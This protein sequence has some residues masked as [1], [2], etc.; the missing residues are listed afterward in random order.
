MQ[1]NPIFVGCGLLRRRNKTRMKKTLRTFFFGLVAF[2]GLSAMAQSSLVSTRF[3]ERFDL[4]SGPDS[5]TSFHTTPST[6]VPYWNDTTAFFVSPGRSYHAKV[7][8]F[9][10]IIFETNTFSTVGNVFVRLTFDQICKVHFGQQGYIMVSNNNGATWTRLNN[11]HYQGPSTNFSAASPYFN[12]ISYVNPSNFPYWGGITLTGTGTQPTQSWWVQETFNVSNLLGGGPSGTGNGFAQCKVRFI[13]EYR[14]P[15]GAANPAGWFVDNVKVDAAPCELQA[16]SYTFNFN[17]RKE[18]IGAR[19]FISEEVRLRVRDPKTQGLTSGVDSVVLFYNKNNSGWQNLNMT[20]SLTTACPDSAYYN[21]IFTGLVVGDTIDWYLELYDCTSCMNKTRVPS[22]TSTPN[23]NTFWRAPSPPLVCGTAAPNSFPFVVTTFP[24]T[25]TFDNLSWLAGSGTGATGTTHRGIFP[26]SNPPTGKNWTVT[27]GAT[28][29]GFAWSVRTGSTGTFGTG[30]TGDN[31]TGN[32][33]YLYTEASQGTAG[34][35]TTLI[36]PCIQLKNLNHAVLEFYYHKF[37]ANMGDLILDIDTNSSLTN[38]SP[39]WKLA[40]YSLPG[41][42]QGTTSAAWKKALVNLDPYLGKNIRI[43]FRAT[44]TGAATVDLG[45]MAIDD[46][47]VYEPA[48]AEM[49]LLTWT[50]PQNGFC[51][52][53]AIEPIRVFMR[54]N[55]SVPTVRIPVGYKLWINNNPPIIVRDTL[56]KT[57][58]LGDTT[59]YTFVPK[60]NMSAF[61]NYTLKVFVAAVGDSKR[62]NDTIGPRLIEHKAPLQLFPHVLTFDDGTWASGNGTALNPGTY[63]TTEWEALPAPITGEYTWMVENGLTT[64]TNTGPRFD[65]SCEGNYLYTEASFGGNSPYAFWQ[66]TRCISLTGMTNPVLTFYYHMYGADINAFTVQVVKVG[67]NVWTNIPSA[68]IAVTPAQHT[69]QTNDWKFF[70]VN[71]STYA[72]QIVKLRLVVRKTNAGDKADVAIDNM[73]IHDRAANDVGIE[74]VTRP[75]NSTAIAT[76]TISPIVTIRNFGTTAKTTVPLAFR[77]KDICAPASA[78]TYTATYTGNIAPGASVSYTLTTLPVYYQGDFEIKAWTTLAGDGYAFNDTAQRIST[79]TTE[80][81]IPFG[82]INFEGCAGDQM[83]F[84]GQATGISNGTSMQMWEFG[85][86]NKG[87]NFN[88]AAS[89]NN[90]WVTGL[91]DNYHPGRH[92]VLRVPTLNNFDTIVGAELRFKHKWDFGTDDGGCVEYFNNNQWNLLGNTSVNVGVNWYGSS[93]GSP[94]IL[95][96]PGPGWAGNSGG[97]WVSSSIPLNVWNF[98]TNPLRLR[99]RM[100][101]NSGGR[102]WAMDDFELY[103]PPQNSAAPVLVDTR[104]YIIIPG[105]TSHVKVKIQNSGAKRLDSCLVRYQVNGGAWTNYETIVFS[106][107]LPR[108]STRWYEFDQV[109]V[110]GGAGNYN[111]CVQ[112]ARPNNKQ[113]NL[114]SDDQLCR[115]FTT[116]DEVIITTSNGYCNDF[117]NPATPAWLPL[118]YKNKDLTHDWEMGTPAQSVISQAYSGSKAWMTKLSSNYSSMTQSALHTPFFTLDTNKVYRMHFRHNMFSE[119]YHDGGSVDWSYDGGIT[120]FTLGNVFISGLWYNTVHVTSLDLVR[121]GWSGTS[122]GWDSSVIHFTVQNPGK[123]VFRFR[124]GSD[125]TIMKEGWAVDDFC[126]K[127]APAGIP[128]DIIGIGQEEIEIPGLFLGDVVP[129]PTNDEALFQFNA[130]SREPVTLRIANIHGQ[131]MSLDKIRTENGVNLYKI[132]TASWAPGM[133][134]LSVQYGDMTVTKRFLVQH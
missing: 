116:L 90:A 125:Y 134:L 27:P 123:L 73:A 56:T 85:K 119:Q 8:P 65:R 98:N 58:N 9:D 77:I 11:T 35:N 15:Q 24:W 48:P 97:T 104:E 132:Q 42:T 61:A 95:G 127:E 36:T 71:L 76:P 133:Y 94:N 67:E 121:P 105:D 49:E 47:K 102:G 128:A 53:S 114:A 40:V 88:S 45:D 62:I 84:F 19:Y 18:P 14:S 129:N 101:G 38:A 17:P 110:N 13:L 54:N 25:E 20:A 41:Q 86:P 69:D 83:G 68:S 16:P 51:S 22:L 3:H 33:K 117:E 52:Y 59:S 92:E 50:K 32:G 99:F 108:G 106:P 103:V 91:N 109:W 118:H 80:Y 4:P 124:F 113:D 1:Q 5:V 21:Y 12:E 57:L 63:G 37:G 111:L 43:R 30:P 93:Y 81:N 6:T 60:V 64:T 82:P 75:V 96:L 39:D 131:I 78:V 112:S 130:S 70:T 34:A 72:N 79:G 126:L 46:I 100:A 29:T 44:K 23:I 10:S 87:A 31:T 74:I 89:G 7:V 26:T 2:M 122:N 28:S 120:W 115:T 107:P 66:S 55:G